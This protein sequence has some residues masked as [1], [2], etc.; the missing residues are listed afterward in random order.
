VDLE[1]RT[2]KRRKSKRARQQR[3]VRMWKQEVVKTSER[4]KEPQRVKTSVSKE[5]PA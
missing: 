3:S 5:K 1:N 4:R 2:E